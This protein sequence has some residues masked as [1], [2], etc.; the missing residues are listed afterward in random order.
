MSSW[1]TRRSRGK[2]ISSSAS[3]GRAVASASTLPPGNA[4][5]PVVDHRVA[6]ASTAPRRPSKSDEHADRGSRGSGGPGRGGRSAQ[7]SRRRATSVMRWSCGTPAHGGAASAPRRPDALVVSS[8]LLPPAILART[9]RLTARAG[10]HRRPHR[11]RRTS[12]SDHVAHGD[13]DW[14]VVTSLLRATAWAHGQDSPRW[15]LSLGGVGMTRPPR[16]SPPPPGRTTIRSSSAA[17]SCR[18]P[19]G[20]TVLRILRGDVSTRRR[21]AKKVPATRAE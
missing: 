3:R 15:G 16:S 8:W 4:I 11:C 2:P 9:S 7:R 1:L 12:S 17:D 14:D 21:S 19:L 6:A 18:A 10:P 13:V 5:T 20:V